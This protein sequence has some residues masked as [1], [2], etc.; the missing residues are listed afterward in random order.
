MKYL[1]SQRAVWWHDILRKNEWQT[2]AMKKIL[3]KE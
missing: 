2:R 1:L 3:P